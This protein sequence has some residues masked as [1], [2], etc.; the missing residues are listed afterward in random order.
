[1]IGVVC[2]KEM[3]SRWIIFFFIVRLFVPFGMFSQSIWAILGY[4]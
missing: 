3:G 1:L 2:A 4:S